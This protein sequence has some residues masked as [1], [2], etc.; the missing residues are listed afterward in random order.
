MTRWIFALALLLVAHPASA[1]GLSRNYQHNDW[2]QNTSAGAG[3]GCGNREWSPAWLPSMSF[4]VRPDKGLTVSGSNVTAWSDSSP[5]GNNLSQGTG[6]KQPTYS[7]TGGPQGQPDIVFGGAQSLDGTAAPFNTNSFTLFI[8]LKG[9]SA[10]NSAFAYSCGNASNGVSVGIGVVSGTKREANWNGVA[11]SDDSTAVATTNWE[12]WTLAGTSAPAQSFRVN[13]SAHTI[14]NATTSA[15]TPAAAQNVGSRAGAV[16]F[17][18]SIAEVFACKVP[19]GSDLI[20]Q[21]EWYEAA[22]YGL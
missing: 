4:W 18:G 22:R 9:A 8:V 13:G 5:A 21:A 1:Y 16:N 3:H 19:L 7:A 12:K 10:S 15:I 2:T 6:A 14:T 17:N 11:T 20:Y